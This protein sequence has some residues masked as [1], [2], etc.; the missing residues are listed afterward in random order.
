MNPLHD[1]DVGPEPPDILNAYVEIAG[2]SRNKFEVDKATGVIRF[3]AAPSTG[4][5][6]FIPQT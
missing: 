4:D 6:G 3:A 5:Y 2:G 1:L